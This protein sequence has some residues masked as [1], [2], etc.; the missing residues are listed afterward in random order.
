MNRV[1][2]SL[3]LLLVAGIPAAAPRFFAAAPELCFTAGPVT[4]EFAPGAPAPDYRV[5]IDNSAARPD[6]RI[7]LVDDAELA[8]FSLVDDIA[9]ANSNACPSA[10]LRKTVRLVPA[11]QAAD[12][13]ISVSR[14]ADA[15]DFKLFVY[16]ARVTHQD[17]AAL[18]ALMQHARTIE[19]A[20]HH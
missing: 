2:N 16:S 18:F 17:A 1:R 7:G 9:G 15:A 14:A 11:G 10:G 6:F 4:Y 20:Q 5:R 12:V 8:D 13:T 19:L 3:I